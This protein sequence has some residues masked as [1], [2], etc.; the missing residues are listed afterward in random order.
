MDISEVLVVS[1][2]IDLVT[3]VVT[4]EKLHSHQYKRSFDA[5]AAFLNRSKIYF[6]YQKSI[7]VF[8]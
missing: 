2:V 3:L 6:I 7:K 1:I 4:F 5:V 8:L